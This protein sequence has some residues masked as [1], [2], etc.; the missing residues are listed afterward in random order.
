MYAIVD[1]RGNQILLKEGTKTRIPYTKECKVGSVIK[2]ENV[3]FY[4][5]GKKKHSGSPFIKN[6][7]FEGKVLSH[8]R[9]S[10]VIVFKQKRRK[11]YQK[12]NGYKDD[13]TLVQINKLSSGKAT[14]ATTK[15]TT[16]KKATTKKTTTKKAT[17]KKTKE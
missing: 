1:Y 7:N 6:I 10:K 11:G 14:K 13:F 15:K 12:K 2:F 3:L 17:T 4:D 9:D 8:E 5:D 16:T